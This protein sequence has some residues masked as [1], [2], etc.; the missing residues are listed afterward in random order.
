MSNTTTKKQ[1]GQVKSDTVR[2]GRP[3][4]NVNY[5]N[6][7][8][9]Y[10]GQLSGTDQTLAKPMNHVSARINGLEGLHDDIGEKSGFITDGYLDKGDTPF[11]EDA[12]FNFLPPGMDINN[13]AM[14]EV[15]DMPMRTVVDI[16]YPEDGWSPKPRDLKE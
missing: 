9:T 13:Q 11:G 5:G 7:P 4:K 8:G 3:P 1:Y 6:R 2:P 14:L 16:S 10:K 15:H 12:K